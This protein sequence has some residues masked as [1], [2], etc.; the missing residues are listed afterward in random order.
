VVFEVSVHLSLAVLLFGPKLLL[1]GADFL[2]NLVAHSIINYLLA[3]PYLYYFPL[4]A[5]P[6]NKQSPFLWVSPMK[7]NR[8]YYKTNEQMYRPGH[9][10]DQA[11][12]LS[13]DALISALKKELYELKDREHEYI[14]LTDDVHN[15][16]SKFSMMKEEKER[17]EN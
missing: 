4:P 5:C 15:C 2:L 7:I 17:K 13:R 14:S 1:D 16:E 8:V 10:Q 3:S 9:S 11:E 12:A 6:P